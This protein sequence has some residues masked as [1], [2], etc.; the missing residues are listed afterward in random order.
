MGR[1]RSERLLVLCREGALAGS[2]AKAPS[3][4]HG[5]ERSITLIRTMNKV[6][7]ELKKAREY[8]QRVLRH[9]HLRRGKLDDKT[10][11]IMED[12]VALITSLLGELDGGE[13]KPASAL[14]WSFYN[15]DAEDKAQAV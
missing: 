14:N 10:Q 2:I 6:V 11:A 3:S 12:R 1:N 9:E 5:Q 8:A 15:G 4:G 13:T 7:E